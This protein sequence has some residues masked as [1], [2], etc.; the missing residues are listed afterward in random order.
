MLKNSIISNKNI[1]LGTIFVTT[2]IAVQTASAMFT[3]ENYGPARSYVWTFKNYY[4]NDPKVWLS[5]FGAQE[6]RLSLADDQCD[7]NEIIEILEKKSSLW[8]LKAN[9]DKVL[10]AAVANNRPAVVVYL[11]KKRPLNVNE[12]D[13]AKNNALTN[14]AGAAYRVLEKAQSGSE[15]TMFK[16][17]WKNKGEIFC[18][19][20][21]EKK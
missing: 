11:T 19:I 4:Y 7:Q 6:C 10:F 16:N 8:N 1:V 2:S 13:E 12:L 15:K 3:P 18:D 5:N 14:G 21:I 9:F 20:K 17:L